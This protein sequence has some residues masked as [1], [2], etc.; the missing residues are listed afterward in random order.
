MEYCVKFYNS[1]CNS[2]L[3]FLLLQAKINILA[4]KLRSFLAILGIMI[5]SGSIVAL[6]C[7]SQLATQSVITKISELGSNIVSVSLL[8]SADKRITTDLIS[9][10]SYSYKEIA[11]YAPIAFSY[12]TI[13]Y[14]GSRVTA[15]LAGTSYDFV[16]IAK[17]K[18]QYGRFI[19]DLD[20]D[21]YC[22]IGADVSSQLG[23]KNIIGQQLKYG[24][25]FCTVVGVLAPAKSNFFI[26]LDINKTVLIAINVLQKYSKDSQVRDVVFALSSSNYIDEA[27]SFLTLAIN[28]DLPKAHAYF[29]NPNELIAQIKYQKRH[30]AILLSII[31]SISLLV[32][33]IGI[34]NIMLVSVVERKREIGIR[35]AVGA[36]VNDIKKM[37]LTEAMLL[38]LIGG[39]LGVLSGILFSLIMAHFSDWPKIIFLMPPLL[40]FF[41]AVLTGVF[42]GFYPAVKAAKLNPVEALRDE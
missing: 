9:T 24:D 22:M 5:G 33:G 8:G 4:N 23:D 31:G 1:A 39:F 12:D 35:L 34:M 26:P 15:G 18:L 28:K 21:E 11:K 3:V 32:G 6:L 40:G 17:L 27:Q 38:S 7:C 10:W 16:N 20:Q 14:N 13:L 42:F 36:H 29:R 30:L 41:V 2:G 19:S 25:R 37:F